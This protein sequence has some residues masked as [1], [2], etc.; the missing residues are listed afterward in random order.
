MG[1]GIFPSLTL[2]LLTKRTS[3]GTGARPATPT[4]KENTS[5]MEAAI[6]GTPRLLTLD[7][8]PETPPLLAPPPALS[9]L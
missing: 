7:P 2:Q 3:T 4:Q 6:L 5:H 8:D 9:V 1:W